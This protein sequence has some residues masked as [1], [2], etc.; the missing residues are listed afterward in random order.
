MVHRD[1]EQEDR[2]VGGLMADALKKREIPGHGASELFFC[3]GRQESCL[4]ELGQL[5]LGEVHVCP[6]DDLMTHTRQ[7]PGVL[8]NAIWVVSENLEVQS[9]LT[10]SP[11]KPPALLVVCAAKGSGA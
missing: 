4:L 2:G 5:L 1:G 9:P 11:G 3:L 8:E 10:E 6:L 7:N